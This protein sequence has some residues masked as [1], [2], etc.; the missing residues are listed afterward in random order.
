MESAEGG[1]VR[2]QCRCESTRGALG[3]PCMGAE[4]ANEQGH[5]SEPREPSRGADTDSK[6]EKGPKSLAWSSAG[7]RSGVLYKPQGA[8]TVWRAQARADGRG[9]RSA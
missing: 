1:E 2:G 9:R 7:K 6:Q 3:R 8:G 5:L 4:T